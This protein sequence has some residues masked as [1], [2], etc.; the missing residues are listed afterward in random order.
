MQT[1]EDKYTNQ[2]RVL[3]IREMGRKGKCLAQEYINFK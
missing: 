3:K 2:S 1:N